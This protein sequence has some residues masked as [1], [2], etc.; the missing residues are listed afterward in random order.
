MKGANTITERRLSGSD[1]MLKTK[2]T[3]TIVTEIIGKP[4]GKKGF[5]RREAENE[6]VLERV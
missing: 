3:I 6:G 4:E 5:L 1:K 2:K